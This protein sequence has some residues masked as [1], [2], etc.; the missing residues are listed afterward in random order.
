MAH[1]ITTHDNVTTVNVVNLFLNYI[2]ELHGLPKKVVLETGTQFTTKFTN[3]L[4]KWLDSKLALSMAYQ[5]QTAGQSERSNEIVEMFLGHYIDHCEE[6]W[7]SLLPMVEFTYNNGVN[8]STG[9]L[10]F[11]NCYWFN[12][13]LNISEDTTSHV[14]AT[15]KH[16]EFLQKGYNEVKAALTLAK[17]THKKYYDANHKAEEVMNQGDK[18]WLNTQNIL[19]DC[20]THKLTHK[21]IGPYKV[22][23][24]VRSHAYKLALPCTMK[25]HP[26]FHMPLLKKWNPEPHGH[27][28]PQPPPVITAEG[29]EEYV[30]EKIISFRK[31]SWKIEYLVK[32]E[33]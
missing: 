30:I 20:P 5:P 26:V 22:I 29:E 24:R 19:T 6:N 14:L 27:D 15:D 7:V 31:T 8:V 17:E 11:Q 28:Q 18:V 33:G 16:A 21:H 9:K 10:L 13:W 25:V 2:W 23:A 4:S 1:F 3:T 32:W 12:P